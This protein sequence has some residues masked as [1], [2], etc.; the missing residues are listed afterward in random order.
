[1]MHKLIASKYLTLVLIHDEYILLPDKL[2]F[3]IISQM[4]KLIFPES[5]R[6]GETFA[7]MSPILKVLQC[8]KPKVIFKV[9]IKRLDG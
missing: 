1:M 9:K 7:Y 5:I 2:I 6:N 8:S 4:D 3:S